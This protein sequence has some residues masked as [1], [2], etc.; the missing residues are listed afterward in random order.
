MRT[1]KEYSKK[2]STRI[3]VDPLFAKKLKIDSVRSG[4]KVVEYT[5][6]LCRSSGFDVEREFEVKNGK[7][8]EKN[9]SLFR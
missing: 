2:E 4:K 6:D 8:S 3:W 7:K 5:R 9:Y 1:K